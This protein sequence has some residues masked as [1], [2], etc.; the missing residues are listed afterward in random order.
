M[1]LDAR[2][3]MIQASEAG[4]FHTDVDEG[5]YIHQQILEM[6]GKNVFHTFCMTG[7]KGKWINVLGYSNHNSAELKEMAKEF[8]LP[9]RFDTCNWE[10]FS[11]KPMPSDW[12]EGKRYHFEVKT[13]PVIRIAGKKGEFRKGSEVDAFLTTI[14]QSGGTAPAR[15]DVYKEWLLVQ[16]GRVQAVKVEQVALIGF[17][18]TKLLRRTQGLNRVVKI[19]ERPEAHLKGNLVIQNGEK[20]KDLIVAGIGRHNSFGFGMLLL[21]PGDR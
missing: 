8:A 17:R 1:Q 5:Y 14:K 21:R 6:F 20:F 7:N 19:L 13:C 10:T 9:L 12:E 4:L 15:E 2:K 11:S 16:F 18:R 3:L